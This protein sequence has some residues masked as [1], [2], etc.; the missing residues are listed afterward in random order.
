MFRIRCSM[1][2]LKLPASGLSILMRP[3]TCVRVILTSHYS[4]E[5]GARCHGHFPD[6]WVTTAWQTPPTPPPSTGPGSWHNVYWKWLVF[7]MDAQFHHLHTPPTVSVYFWWQLQSSIN[8]RCH[9]D[10]AGDDTNLLSVQKSVCPFKGVKYRYM[11]LFI[12]ICLSWK[13]ITPGS[14]W[15]QSWIIFLKLNYYSFAWLVA[16]G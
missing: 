7:F 3:S 14:Y 11:Q 13:G 8:E 2:G 10:G 12:R 15:G 16:Q 5:D 1:V 4:V 9:V 6:C